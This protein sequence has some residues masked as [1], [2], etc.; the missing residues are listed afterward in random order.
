MIAGDVSPVA[1]FSTAHHHYELKYSS[2]DGNIQKLFGFAVTDSF[3]SEPLSST[4][5]SRIVNEE[6][7]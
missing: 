7:Y 5:V 4:L 6:N 2:D 3:D 1:M